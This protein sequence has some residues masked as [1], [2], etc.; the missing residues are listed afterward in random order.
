MIF[1][2]VEFVSA[3][4]Y[5]TSD[6]LPEKH[7]YR[8]AFFVCPLLLSVIFLLSDIGG[9]YLSVAS[10]FLLAYVVAIIEPIYIT[11]LNSKFASHIRSFANSFSSFVQTTFI[12]VGFYLY[13]QL[14]NTVG[15]GMVAQLSSLFPLLSVALIYYYFRSQSGGLKQEEVARSEG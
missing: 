5:F 14:S 13:S 12:S 3:V 9:I 10:F 1:A 7:R 11:Y 4:G 15:F 6:K 8:I 2:I